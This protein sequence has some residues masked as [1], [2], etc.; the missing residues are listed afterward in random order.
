MSCGQG[1]LQWG[2]CEDPRPRGL[3]FLS[4]QLLVED[5]SVLESEGTRKVIAAQNSCVLYSLY[6]LMSLYRGYPASDCMLPLSGSS[7]PF[8]SE[9][10]LSKIVSY[11]EL[12]S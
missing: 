10:C 8:I 4:G 1:H 6:S 12:K 11:T 9:E 2:T 7:P 5:A 3:P